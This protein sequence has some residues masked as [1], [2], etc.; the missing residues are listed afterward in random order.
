MEEKSLCKE[1]VMNESITLRILKM[2]Q[3]IGT[4]YV[5]SIDAYTLFTM[6]ESDII[7][8]SKN[9]KTYD[10]IQREIKSQKV[11]YIKNYLTSIDATMPNSIILNIT[12]DKIIKKTND[13]ITIKNTK[14]TFTIIDGQHRLKGFEDSKNFRF[15]LSITFFIDLPKE[16]QSRVFV[17][18][19]SEQTKVD[20][21]IS[22][23]Q[24]N[25]EKYFT[26][27]KMVADLSIMFAKDLDSPW[28]NKIK[29]IGKKDELS[30]DAAISLSA[31]AQRILTYVYN[32]KK[33]FNKLRNHLI[34]NDNNLS[35]L[36]NSE[37]YGG[38][39]LWEFYI[40]HDELSLYKVLLNY[41]NALKG[42]FKYDWNNKDGLLTKTT[43]YNAYMTLFKDLFEVGYNL[44]TLEENYFY[45]RLSVLKELDKTINTKTYGASG[46]KASSDLYKVMRNKITV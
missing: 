41:F 43:G 42:I 28:R 11:H 26:P 4:L 17:T 20:P 22:F 12:S 16:E 3:T 5:S 8:L 45:K 23:Y 1:L 18:I 34:E 36:V 32:D 21:S 29:L 31:F 46:A 19:N 30:E 24:E 13:S 9:T 7:R 40:S 35:S 38:S 25:K 15:D 6:S 44:G 27:R 39:I 14:D 33:Y 10:G 2:S 37:S